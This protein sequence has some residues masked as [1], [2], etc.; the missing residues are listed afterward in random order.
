MDGPPKTDAGD[1]DIP[2]PAWLCDDLAAMLTERKAGNPGSLDRSG[3][4][5]LRPTGLPLNLDKF[6]QDVVRPA[7]RAAGLPETL[8]TYDIR[9][10]HASLLIDQGANPL[11][12]AQRMG[13]TD[14]AVTLRVYGHLFAGAQ[15][16][17][18]DRLDSLRQRSSGG[19]GMSDIVELGGTSR[20]GKP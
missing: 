8:R 15:E 10:S 2:I 13:H 20:S 12:V 3:Y 7:L 18:T 16:E 19:S 1:R 17:L 4:L 5:F 11:A 14:P 9:H 6:R